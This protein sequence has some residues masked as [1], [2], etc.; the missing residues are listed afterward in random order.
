M[1]YGCKQ[2]TVICMSRDVLT[3]SSDLTV[4]YFVI[5]MSMSVVMKLPFSRVG[6][7][8]PPSQSHSLALHHRT[9]IY[10]L[11]APSSGRPA[12]KKIGRQVTGFP[13]PVNNTGYGT[14]MVVG[15]GIVRHADLAD[16]SRRH[17]FFFFF[18]SLSSSERISWRSRRLLHY[19][20]L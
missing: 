10:F 14:V 2:G 5:S 6:C 18:Y 16:P 3:A 13:R 9:L 19:A 11:F 4:Q 7:I 20:R 1:R 8:I 15:F 12:V 17:H